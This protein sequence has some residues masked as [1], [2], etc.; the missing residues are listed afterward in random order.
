[1]EANYELLES[2]LRDRRRQVRNEDLLTELD[3]YSE[4]YDEERDGAE[5]GMGARFKGYPMAGGLRN[6][7]QKMVEVKE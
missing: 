1:M 6:V 3:Y 4:E 5:T 7:E 2:L